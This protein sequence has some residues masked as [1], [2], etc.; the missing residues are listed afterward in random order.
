MTA[1]SADKIMELTA[2]RVKTKMP[3]DRV[4]LGKAGASGLFQ[5]GITGLCQDGSLHRE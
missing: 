4:V 3:Q 2:T 1:G 5:K